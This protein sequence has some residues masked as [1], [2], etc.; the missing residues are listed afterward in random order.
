MIDR[1]EDRKIGHRILNNVRRAIERATGDDTDKLF[2]IRRF[3]FA[4]LQLDER[5]RKKAIKDR[6][7]EKNP[8]CHKCKKKFETEKGVHLHR[9]NEDRGYTDKNCVLM[10]AVCHREHHRK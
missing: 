7:Y 3:V 10:H 9:K 5:A 8:R 6:L 4:R 1:T 2:Y